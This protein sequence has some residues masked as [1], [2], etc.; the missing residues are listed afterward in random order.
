L[1]V[2]AGTPEQI[3]ATPESHTGQWL[4]H[5]LPSAAETAEVRS[6]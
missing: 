1:I 5:V 6:A 2:A 3:A 4:K